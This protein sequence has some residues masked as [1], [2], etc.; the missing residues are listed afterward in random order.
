VRGVLPAICKGYFHP[1]KEHVAPERTYRVQM[2][3]LDSEAIDDI[4]KSGFSLAKT[5][6]ACCKEDVRLTPA[7]QAV[8]SYYKKYNSQILDPLHSDQVK[9]ADVENTASDSKA[10]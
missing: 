7:K 9:Q 3:G 6:T 8:P 10:Y 4:S 2:Q 1:R 5:E